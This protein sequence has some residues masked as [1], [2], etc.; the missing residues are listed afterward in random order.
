MID[1]KL[2]TPSEIAPIIGFKRGNDLVPKIKSLSAQSLSMLKNE[3]PEK[4]EVFMLGL[5][6]KKM[7]IGISD[8]LDLKK[9]KEEKLNPNF[10]E[11]L[12][13]KVLCKKLNIGID[14]F[15]DYNLKEEVKR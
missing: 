1:L 15:L 12:F 4:Y 10:K 5:I 3:N 9:L 11:T 14:D 6:C 2:L 13:L 8:I 7:N